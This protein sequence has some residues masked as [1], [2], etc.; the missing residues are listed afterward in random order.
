MLKHGKMLN[1]NLHNKLSEN[2]DVTHGFTQF[3]FTVTYVN[4]GFN[5]P[6]ENLKTRGRF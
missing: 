5:K 6:F 3:T 1:K 2:T 4:P